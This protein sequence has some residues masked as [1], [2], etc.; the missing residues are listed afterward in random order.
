MVARGFQVAF[1]A[2]VPSCLPPQPQFLFLFLS[3]YFTTPQSRLF[4]LVT[5]FVFALAASAPHPHAIRSLPSPDCTIHQPSLAPLSLPLGLGASAYC[6]RLA[7]SSPASLLASHSPCVPVVPRGQ[8]TVPQSGST[9]HGASSRKCEVDGI[10]LQLSS[11]IRPS[12]LS[13]QLMFDLA[14]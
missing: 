14:R 3:W 7:E 11:S 4:F 5:V 9:A 1:P 12:C 8:I 6:F 10:H 13:N 2:P